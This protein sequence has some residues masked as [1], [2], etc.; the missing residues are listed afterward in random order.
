MVK[1]HFIIVRVIVLFEL[2]LC[3]TAETLV[4]GLLVCT[5]GTVNMVGIKVVKMIN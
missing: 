4:M 3:T 1:Y 5:I 2:A